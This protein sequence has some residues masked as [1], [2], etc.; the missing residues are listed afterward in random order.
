MQNFPCFITYV[1]TYLQFTYSEKLQFNLGESIFDKF[2][3]Y[4]MIFYC[5]LLRSKIN[6]KVLL[7]FIRTSLCKKLISFFF[8]PS[9]IIYNI[10]M[11]KAQLYIVI[12]MK[13]VLLP[14]ENLYIGIQTGMI[15]KKLIE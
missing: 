1:L 2:T 3:Y 5:I 9:D 14:K 15:K 11:I 12:G 6:H 4:A 13:Q 8:A 10:C 7:P